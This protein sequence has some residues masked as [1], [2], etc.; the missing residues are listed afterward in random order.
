LRRL[1]EGSKPVLAA[2]LADAG[3]WEFAD[4]EVRIRFADVAVAR[5]LPDADRKFL[6]R[7]VS[8]VLGRTVRVQF[9]DAGKEAGGEN[10]SGKHGAPS[11]LSGTKRA[12]ST[13]KD[14]DSPDA[15]IE[16]LVRRDPDVQ[17]FESLFG[18]PVTDIRRRRG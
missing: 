12:P 1:E 7:L 4:A 14:A 17:E 2:L 8:D 11:R 9:S 18:K 16:G 15:S 3:Q 6:D 10:P 13:A 5:V